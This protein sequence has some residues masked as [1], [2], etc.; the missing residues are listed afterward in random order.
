M[1]TPAKKPAK[2]RGVK[3]PGMNPYTY[4]YRRGTVAGYRDEQTVIFILR[5]AAVLGQKL[6]SQLVDIGHV[7]LLHRLQL[8]LFVKQ[9][10]RTPTLGR[11]RYSTLQTLSPEK[12]STL[13][14]IWP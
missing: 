14:G 2:V 4:V 8:K 3:K 1:P 11:G 5:Q 10:P 12:S 9:V 6:G 7:H 13:D